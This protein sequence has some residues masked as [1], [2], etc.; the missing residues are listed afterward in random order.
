MST[1]ESIG[2]LGEGVGAT[3]D[4]HATGPPSSPLKNFVRKSWKPLVCSTIALT[5]GLTIALYFY[6]ALGRWNRDSIDKAFTRRASGMAVT[7]QSHI[8]T[9]EVGRGGASPRKRKRAK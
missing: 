5:I 3:G 1:T 4:K 6:V 7:L 9:F 8:D 2:A